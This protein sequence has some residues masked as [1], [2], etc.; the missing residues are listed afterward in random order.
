MT[1][2]RS[3]HFTT[4]FGCQFCPNVDVDVQFAAT[5]HM[6]AISFVTLDKRAHGPTDRH[7]LLKGILQRKF[8]LLPPVCT[9]AM[10]LALTRLLCRGLS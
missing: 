7:L 9:L 1:K 8:L 6:T 5:R 2:K 3:R 10:T 4:L